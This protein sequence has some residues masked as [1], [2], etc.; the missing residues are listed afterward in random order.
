MATQA[1]I[2]RC[3]GGGHQWD[4]LDAERLRGA[5]LVWVRWRCLQCA[6]HRRFLV[7]G[8]GFTLKRKYDYVEG[9]R[10]QGAAELAPSRQDYRA[11]LVREA[12]KRRP[13]REPLR[14]VPHRRAAAS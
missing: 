5:G 10:W 13:G 8:D 2:R 9:Y 1:E 3:W 14:V 4:L 11:A 6:S 12:L 7:D